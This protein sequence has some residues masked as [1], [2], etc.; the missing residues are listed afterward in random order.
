MA[1]MVSSVQVDLLDEIKASWLADPE[2][3]A[4]IH[5]CRFSLKST[6]PSSLIN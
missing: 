4:L 2:L 1:L 6:L 5:L 3:N